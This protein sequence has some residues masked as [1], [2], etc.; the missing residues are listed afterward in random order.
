MAKVRKYLKSKLSRLR[1]PKRAIGWCLLLL[2]LLNRIV[3]ILWGYEEIYHPEEKQIGYIALDF[4]T[5]LR[6]S[7]ISYQVDTYTGGSLFLGLLA[8]PFILVFGTSLFSLKILALFLSLLTF[9]VVIAWMRRFF[10]E[11]AAIYAALLWIFAPPIISFTSLILLGSHECLLPI[12]LFL[13]LFYAADR[14]D[15]RASILIFSAAGLAG[16]WAFSFSYINLIAIA[17]AVCTLIFFRPKSGPYDGAP[18]LLF[19]GFGFTAGAFLWILYNVTHDFSGLEFIKHSIQFNPLQ[20][21]TILDTF[22]KIYHFLRDISGW[23]ASLHPLPG[24][25]AQIQNFMYLAILSILV[26]YDLL[27]NR[28]IPQPTPILFFRIY[29][30]FFLLAYSMSIHQVALSSPDPVAWKNRYFTPLFAFLLLYGAAL[31]SRLRLGKYLLALLLLLGIGSHVSSAWNKPFGEVFTQLSFRSGIRSYLWRHPVELPF[32]TSEQAKSYFRNLSEADFKLRKRELREIAN[33]ASFWDLGSPAAMAAVV[34][35]I[36]DVKFRR[37]FIRRWP[38]VAEIDY[39]D[40]AALGRVNQILPSIPPSYAK[41]FIYGVGRSFMLGNADDLRDIAHYIESSGLPHREL[42]FLAW[43]NYFFRE[44]RDDVS[45]PGT[46]CGKLNFI[47]QLPEADRTWFYRGIGTGIYRSFRPEEVLAS[48]FK[49]LSAACFQGTKEDLY[50]GI[51]WYLGRRY[52]LRPER[53]RYLISTFDL[54]MQSSAFEGFNYFLSMAAV[55]SA[56][57]SAIEG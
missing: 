46:K 10:G 6:A 5:S 31:L 21:F 55:E 17:A 27:R 4:L 37:Y 1:I 26:A 52:L 20:G 42:L 23:G 47:H 22:K 54:S 9:L 48:N 16:G 3:L 29:P 32:R 34:L 11:K 53:V 57:S 50:W 13:Y 33:Q 36:P 49:F 15:R 7:L 14:K 25:P 35:E 43:G 28:R 30:V 44:I 18:H 2:F 56:P 38:A 24:L 41:D 8:I 12:L 39:T 40:T 19:F 51:G 45:A